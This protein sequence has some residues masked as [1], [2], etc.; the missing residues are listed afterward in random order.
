MFELVDG[1]PI[2]HSSNF[3][4]HSV[5]RGEQFTFLYMIAVC[6]QVDKPQH[7]FKAMFNITLTNRTYK[8]NKIKVNSKL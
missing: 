3:Y 8:K 4:L 5:V 7:S 6:T 1:G 2:I